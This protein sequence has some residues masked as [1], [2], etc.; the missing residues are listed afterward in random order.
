MT[1]AGQSTHDFTGTFCIDDACARVKFTKR[2]TSTDQ[3][4][5]FR[6]HTNENAAM[7]A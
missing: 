3:G 4:M 1:A 2:G 5:S 7:N 6:R